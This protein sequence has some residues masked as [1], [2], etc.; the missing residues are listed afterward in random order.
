VTV[1]P[2]EYAFLAPPQAP[3]ELGRLGTYRILKVLGVG[4][5]GIVFQ[6]ED[7]HLKR[8]VAIK[9]MKPSIAAKE[10]SRQR[11]F[12]EAAMTAQ[13]EHDHIVTIYQVAEDRG[14]PF[15]A[16]KLLQGESLDERLKREGGWMALSEVLRI[17]REICEG[18]AA[19]HDRGLVHRDVKP[20]N[21][22][23]E[24]PRDRVK[25]VDFGLARVH[26]EDGR[27]TQTGTLMGT[28]AYMAPEQASS[29]DVD[30][31][32]DLFSVGCV[33]YRMCTGQ[34]PFKGKDTMSMLRALAVETPDPPHQIAP[35]LPRAL[36]DLIMRLL[37][38]DPAGRPKSARE[39]ARELDRL[40]Q[41][42]KQ[43]VATLT[44]GAGHTAATAE[45]A[46]DLRRILLSALAQERRSAEE[47]HQRRREPSDPDLDLPI[48]FAPD[49][50]TQED[51]RQQDDTAHQVVSRKRKPKPRQRVSDLERKVMRFAIIVGTA[52]VLLLLYL[53]IL[54]PL[55]FYVP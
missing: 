13:L 18:L 38:K 54:R 34:L 9:A 3:G 27:L 31:R 39:T 23:L 5:M 55:L 44:A 28:P 26:T 32:T 46:D 4:G 29:E 48:P 45:D 52:I 41:E 36:S 35:G 15:L 50:E 14:T 6:A 47:A 20:A 11:F 1:S 12:R 19:A 53:L 49:A 25:I 42:P 8:Q 17:G 22:W 43:P 2:E 10:T 40:A 21:I 30:H 33:L 7:L 24:A 16:M 37:S 51:A